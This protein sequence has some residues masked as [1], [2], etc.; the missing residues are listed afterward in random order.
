MA[1]IVS[2]IFVFLFGI[3]IGSFLNVCIYRMGREES[4]VAP[5][6]HCP[7]CQKPIRWFD[8]IPL[9][10]YLV[11]RGRCRDCG[12][13]ISVRYFLVELLTGLLFFALFK[14]FNFSEHFF[15]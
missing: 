11:L 12:A 4:I 10:S 2:G 3:C 5:A 6:S 1:E 14:E 8:N 15:A 7:H 9:F 13:R